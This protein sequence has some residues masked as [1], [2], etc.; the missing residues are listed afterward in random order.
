MKLAIRFAP[1]AAIGAV[2][3]VLLGLLSASGAGNSADSF[4]I[5]L[6]TT[7]NTATSLGTRDECLDVNAG[8]TINIDVTATNVP[9]ATGMISFAYALLYDSSAIT[10]SA[11]NNA[12][13]L[14]TAPGYIE[15]DAGDPVPDSDGNY[16]ATVVDITAAGVSGTGFLQRIT[17]DVAPGATPGGYTLTLDPANTA[18]VGTTGLSYPPDELFGAR[19]AV[20]VTCASLGTPTPPPSFLRGDVDCNGGVNSVDALKVLRFVAGLTVSQQPGCP[21]IG[22]GLPFANGDVDCNNNVN[23]VDALKILRWVAGLSVSQQPG[24]TPIGT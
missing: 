15:F 8:D 18:H 1:V 24:C 11:K 16:V 20:G 7:G 9:A 4:A 14:S 12:G 13:L 21:L 6:D 5:D 2:M 23:S 3:A 22:T 19:L 17:I 10:I